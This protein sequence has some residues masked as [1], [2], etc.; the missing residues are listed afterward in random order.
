MHANLLLQVLSN[1]CLWNL[2]TGLHLSLVQ[3]LTYAY[4]GGLTSH[5]M[6]YRKISSRI[7][8]DLKT[9]LQSTAQSIVSGM[10]RICHVA[11]HSSPHST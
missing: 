1:R 8:M 11:S 4:S 10:Q 5:R 2:P 6:Q 7:N 3:V 9:G